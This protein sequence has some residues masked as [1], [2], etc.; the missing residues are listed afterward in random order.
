MIH[1]LEPSGAAMRPSRVAASFRTTQGRPR[2]RWASGRARSDAR[3]LGRR[4]PDLDLDPGFPESVHAPPGDLRVGI[5]DPDDH[6]PD[7]GRDEGVGARRGST[8]VGARLEGHVDRG[9]PSGVTGELQ[10]HHFGV[11]PA[12]RSGG[13]F[14]GRL[15]AFGHHHAPTQGLGEVSA[16]TPRPRAMAS[17]IQASSSPA[18][19]GDAHG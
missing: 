2:R 16:R 14:G 13:S 15:V 7:A 1:W 5:Q 8:V 4:H 18:V 17:A 6:P 9:V 19:M 3:H 12:R 11:G 10:G